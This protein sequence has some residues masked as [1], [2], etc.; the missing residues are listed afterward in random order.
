MQEIGAQRRGAPDVMGD[1]GGRLEPPEL[2]QRGQPSPMSGQ[3]DVL[4][5]R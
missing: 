1:D 3:R 2:E 5:D 4:D